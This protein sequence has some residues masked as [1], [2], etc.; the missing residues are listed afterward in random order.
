MADILIETTL[1]QYFPIT[2]LFFRGKKKVL[3]P[4]E[5]FVFDSYDESCPKVIIIT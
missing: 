1:S 4:L 3:N 5:K 2:E